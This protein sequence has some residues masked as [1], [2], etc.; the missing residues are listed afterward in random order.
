MATL[1]KLRGEINVKGKGI[2]TTYF[3]HPKGA[4]AS[5]LSS[6]IRL[7][8]GVPLAQAPSL[9]RQTSQH[10]SFSA[11]VFEMLQATKRNSNIPSTCKFFK[12]I[13]LEKNILNF[14]YQLVIEHHLHK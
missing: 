6:P 12:D 10:G 1:P 3:V 2:M 9:Q 14:S 5:Q 11:I 7:P 8:P 13:N 4:T